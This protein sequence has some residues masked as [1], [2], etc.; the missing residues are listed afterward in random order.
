MKKLFVTMAISLA[1]LGFISC[2]D[3]NIA[4]NSGVDTTIYASDEELQ[5]CIDRGY[6]NYNISRYYALSP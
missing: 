3:I 4:E 2:N 6:V 5:Q 1:L